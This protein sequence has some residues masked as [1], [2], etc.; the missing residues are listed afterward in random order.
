M[1]NRLVLT[2]IAC[3]FLVGC[4]GGSG[5][6]STPPPP[7]P[8]PPPT[9][10]AP[11]AMASAPMSVDEADIVSLDASSSTDA[12]G[13]TLS[14]SWT[15]SSGVMVSLTDPTS[16]I[17]SFTAPEVA[18]DE[19]LSFTVTVS[20]GTD[21]SA[22]TVETTVINFLA[23]DEFPETLSFSFPEDEF[24]GFEDHLASSFTLTAN[25][26]TS[27]ENTTISGVDADFFT[28]LSFNETA[29]NANGVK[30]IT[31]VLGSGASFN[32]EDPQDDNADNIYE[33]DVKTMFQGRAITA[34]GRF[35]VTDVLDAAEV[36]AA[37]IVFGEG[38]RQ[39][40]T[41]GNDQ[42]FG[43]PAEIIS[44]IT[45]DSKPEIGVSIQTGSGPAAAYIVT[46]ESYSPDDATIIDYARSDTPV[47]VRF[48]VTGTSTFPEFNYLSSANSAVGVDVL[49][50]DESENRL[51]LFKNADASDLGE[52]Q[53]EINA[54]D[55]SGAITYDFPPEIKPLG[56]LIGD[57]NGDGLTDIFVR[58]MLSGVVHDEF[59]IIFGSNAT[60]TNQTGN[61][62]VTLKHDGDQLDSFS[63]P[64]VLN[65]ELVS[66]YD[67]DGL[68]ELAISTPGFIRRFRNGSTTTLFWIVKGSDLTQASTIDVDIS[69]QEYQQSDEFAEFHDHDNDGVPS[70]L[71]RRRSL[72]CVIDGDDLISQPSSVAITDKGG[73]CLSGVSRL[74]VVLD[75]DGRGVPDVFSDHRL[76]A[77][78]EINMSLI[79]SEDVPLKTMQVEVPLSY[80]RPEFFPGEYLSESGLFVFPSVNADFSG[81]IAPN[82]GA[83]V[84]VNEADLVDAFTNNAPSLQVR[85]PADP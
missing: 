38:S 53:G 9:N 63:L 59:G 71:I 52:L 51:V 28:F 26:A 55:I 74:S 27:F 57:V 30:V 41:A 14:Y 65:V 35:E 68:R 20:D 13:D 61:Y 49:L 10:Q 62:D 29:P 1:I 81:G 42:M 78:E 58:N 39:T 36:E 16:A 77:G 80:N 17:A 56:K 43:A 54:G 25:A 82:F 67:G 70:I 15:Q 73:Q 7:P 50:S 69:P 37:T 11:S 83:L 33:F 18:N 46:S 45:G 19:V 8:P 44:D 34:K 32:F 64:L 24:A 48:N 79:N 5:S 4:G 72:L 21:S 76:I 12:D 60:Q 84:F 85:F 2:G 75:V 22:A 3:T 31:P 47:D 40:N 23:A 66:D 6:G